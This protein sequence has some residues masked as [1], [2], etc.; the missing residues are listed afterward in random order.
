MSTESGILPRVSRGT[1]LHEHAVSESDST[2]RSCLY[3]QPANVH[4][5]TTNQQT[6]MS[7]QPISKR[8]CLYNQPANVHVCT[9]NQQTFMSAQPI[10]KR[11][12]L[13]N[14]S[15]NVHVCTTNQQTFMS[16]QPT[17]KQPYHSYMI[18]YIS[19]IKDVK[20]PTEICF[21]RIRTSHLT[22]TQKCGFAT[23]TTSKEC[24]QTRPKNNKRSE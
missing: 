5:C 15:A 23:P 9:T 19:N 6:F 11:S 1:S 24:Y 2:A 8:S 16:V 7:V 3:N 21:R 12:C 10:S 17:S 20:E 22:S 13:Y 4:V 18:V 14:Q